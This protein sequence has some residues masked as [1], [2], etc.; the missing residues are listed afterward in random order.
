MFLHR[1]GM[2]PFLSSL[3]WAWALRV[4]P[5]QARGF[6]NLESSMSIS[7]ASL[8]FGLGLQARTQ[9][10]SSFFIF[11]LSLCAL[12][13]AAKNNLALSFFLKMFFL[14]TLISCFR[15][16]SN[17]SLTWIWIFASKLE[18]PVPVPRQPDPVDQPDR[19]GEGERRGELDEGP[20]RH[21]GQRG[22][23]PAMDAHQEVSLPLCRTR[24]C[25]ISVFLKQ[26]TDCRAK[27]QSVS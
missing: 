25:F 16:M 23:V 9:W 27:T 17:F 4:E 11:I 26:I 5:R 18:R 21:H 13:L 15:L 12:Q 22:N 3:S 1:G 14:A 19:D 20:Q 24:F 10:P 6:N 8:K 2:S 7:I